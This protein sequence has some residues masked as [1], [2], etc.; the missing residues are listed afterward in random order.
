MK[1]VAY[2][3]LGNGITCIDA[4]YVLPGVACFYLL[5]R[6]GECALIETGTSR[7]VPAL[8]ELMTL[9]GITPDQV[10]YVIPTHVHLDHAGGA[11]TMMAAFPNAQLLIH[12][13]G[14]RH[15]IDPTQLSASA[16]EVYGEKAFRELYGDIL[17]VDATR[18]REINDGD[19]V[20]F[21]G[22]ILEFRHTRGH[23]NHHFCVWDE[24][25]RGWF[26]GDMFGVSYPWWRFGEKVGEEK[27]EQD[28][29]LP[30][31]TPT[32]FD[33]EAYFESLK[34]LG[35]YDP[36]SLYLTHYGEL[37]YSEEKAQLLARQVAFYRDVAQENM[38]DPSK[39][40]ALITENGLQQL[41]QI[42]PEGERQ[43][44]L[45]WL[46][47]DMPLNAQGLQFWQRKIAQQ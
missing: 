2:K 43:Q 41:Q 14:A 25:S 37:E 21:G 3:A 39:L 16:M 7:S 8:Q 35:S 32:Q 47:F 20:D 28:F 9:Q 36:K 10:R 4:N 19:R 42:D 13:R 44:H 26:S 11:G 38:E 12:P 6:A 40:Q 1:E 5:E 33:P 23:A 30:S 45:D 34:L 31:T 46:S 29:V 17:P 15:M 18:V 22:H 24:V 27:G